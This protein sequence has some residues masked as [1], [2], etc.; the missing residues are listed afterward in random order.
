MK[1]KDNEKEKAGHHNECSCHGHCCCEHN[2][3]QHHE[4]DHH[5]HHHEHGCCCEEGIE[6]L[7]AKKIFLYI[8]G[9]VALALAFLPILPDAVRWICAGAVYVTF[10]YSVW[11]E[12]IEGIASGHVFTEF[13]LMCVA[14]VGAIVLLEYAD[15]AAVMYLYALGET[16]SGL[17]GGRARRNIAE[18]IAI[19]PE[20]VTVLKDGTAVVC[21]PT[22]VRVGDMVLVR[23]GERIPLDGTVRAG[24][25]SADTSSV[26]GEQLPTELI[27][28]T[29]CLSGSMLVSG[30]VE[31]EVSHD[32]ENSVAAQ[33][34]AAVEEAS[35]RKAVREKKITRLASVITPVAFGVALVIFG[36][37]SLATGNVTEW[38]RRGLVILV[39]ACPCSL[40]LSV[41]LTYFAGIGSAA[42]Q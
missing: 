30:S 11:R 27:V 7:E 29:R 13:T 8:M 14:S 28:G 17:A 26:T 12:M 40:L 10:G 34:R 37:G 9:A 23:S 21:E 42:G 16:V 22:D 31:I 4:H 3:H 39:C 25:G 1:Q 36:V 24:G 2:G 6:R 32:Y 33:L 15:A 18:L 20:Y 41:P 35:K 38:L 5:D 19:T